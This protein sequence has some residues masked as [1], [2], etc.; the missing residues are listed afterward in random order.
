MSIPYNHEAVWMKAKS[1]INRSFAAL[2]DE[3]FPMA[4]LCAAVSLELL[5]KSVLSQISPLLVA[6]PSDNGRSL[7]L[8]A[9]LPEDTTK[10]K[11][12]SAK[13]LF[14][15]CARAFR[16]FNEKAAVDIA[17]QR[18]AEL[19]SGAT[20][21]SA[22]DD[23]QAWWEQFWS[24]AEVL[25]DQRGNTIEDFVGPGRTA[26]VRMHLLR[27]MENVNRRV[28]SLVEAARQRLE[29]GIDPPKRLGVIYELDD[30]T[31]CPVCEEE[32]VLGG[33][34]VE[35]SEFIADQVEDGTW[36]YE[37]VEVAA[38]TFQ[39]EHCG[40]MLDGELYISVAG[41][42]PTFFVERP[43]EPDLGDYIEYGND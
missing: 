25:V 18:N 7:M 28:E 41:L 33:D 6:D 27:N 16:P 37:Q 32:A 17:A 19:H 43:Y 34:Y 23:P 35:E 2:D 14:S 31:T 20:P 40:L 10:Y 22:I 12:I 29:L 21:Y 4:A 38:N 30:Y 26:E 36:G 39:C 1:F 15:R 42:P 3:D 11:S 13:T 24:T 8:A 9:G 5:A